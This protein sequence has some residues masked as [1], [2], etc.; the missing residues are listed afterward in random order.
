[1]TYPQWSHFPKDAP[2]N[3]I[4]LQIIESFTN[5]EQLIDSKISG[6]SGTNEQKTK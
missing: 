4:A 5:N 2:P 6:I 1:M 3:E